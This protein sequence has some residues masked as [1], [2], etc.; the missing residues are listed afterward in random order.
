MAYVHFFIC[1]I[2][3]RKVLNSNLHSGTKKQNVG[4]KIISKNMSPCRLLHLYK[5][6]NCNAFAAIVVPVPTHTT[7]Y[8]FLLRMTNDSYSIL[9]Y[10]TIKSKYWLSNACKELVQQKLISDFWEIHGVLT[11]NIRWIQIDIYF[12]ERILCIPIPN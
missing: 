12:Q 4:R 11:R 6:H 10:H 1:K 5:G 7:V 2:Q 8:Y 9:L 3:S